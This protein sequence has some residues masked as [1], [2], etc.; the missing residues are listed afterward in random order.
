MREGRI[1]KMKNIII[2]LLFVF[3]IVALFGFAFTIG[4]EKEPAGEKIFFQ[5]NCT[6]CHSIDVLNIKSK[7]KQAVD[8]SKA[9][10][11]L[12]KEFITKFLTKTEKLN[13]KEHKVSF[14]GSEQELNSLAK[15]LVSL[16]SNSAKLRT[17]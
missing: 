9:G 10:D 6:T 4:Q 17:K 14:N 5:N 16:K 15:W 11:K 1:R 12:T 8:L 2:Y 3:S 13:N 7:K